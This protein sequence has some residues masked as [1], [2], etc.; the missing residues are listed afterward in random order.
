[1][2]LF[3]FLPLT[4]WFNVTVVEYFY[5]IAI[6]LYQKILHYAS[7]SAIICNTPDGLRPCRPTKITPFAPQFSIKSLRSP[8]ASAVAPHQISQT[9]R[10][11]HNPR[12]R[13]E[14]FQSYTTQHSPH[15]KPFGSGIAEPIFLKAVNKNRPL[16]GQTAG[17]T[18]TRTVI[19]TIVPV[20]DLLFPTPPITQTYTCIHPVATVRD[21]LQTVW[22]TPR[23]CQHITY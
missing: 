19:S 23:H 22:G 4:D 7:K 8:T 9:N 6:L 1:M 13:P 3:D 5:S 11:L 18:A 21:R 14:G 2:R 10:P 17:P 16:A 20:T 12:Q 15:S